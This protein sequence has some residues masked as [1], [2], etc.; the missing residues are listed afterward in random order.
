MTTQ[1]TRHLQSRILLLALVSLLL[2]GLLAAGVTAFAYYE[3][4]RE[5]AELA[6]EMNLRHHSLAIE[7]YFQRLEDIA[8]QVASRSRIRDELAAYQEDETTL[9]DL[10][11]FTSGKLADALAPSGAAGIIR[12][13]AELDRVLAVGDVEPDAALWPEL[14]QGQTTISR[15]G[16]VEWEGNGYLILAV[17]IIDR[18]DRWLGADIIVFPVEPLA[19]ILARAGDADTPAHLSSPEGVV[20]SAATGRQELRDGL[21]DEIRARL[22]SPPADEWEVQRDNGKVLFVGPVNGDWSLV[23]Q[24]PKRALYAEVGVELGM[25]VGLVLAM[26]ML[27][28]LAMLRMM[29]PLSSQVVE[30]AAALE[31]ATAEQEDLLEYAH[32]FVYRFDNHGQSAYVSPG[33]QGVLGYPPSVLP[34]AIHEALMSPF[35]PYLSGAA[36]PVSGEGGAELPPARVT[37]ERRGGEMVVLELNAR[38]QYRADSEQ[39]IFGVARDV[40]DRE[41]AERRVQHLAHY[42]TLTDLPNRALLDDRL[43][44]ALQRA[45]RRDARLALLFVDLDGFKY[46]ND[47]LGHHRG[48]ELLQAVAERLRGGLRAED[49][50]ARQGGDEFVM[51]VESIDGPREAEQVAQKVLGALGEPFRIGGDELFVGASIGISLFPDDATEA[52][53]LI[54]NADSAMFR[55]KARG[56]NNIQFYTEELTSVNQRRLILEAGLRRAIEGGELEVVYQPQWHLPGRELAGAEALVR[57]RHPEFGVISPAEF[58]PVAEENGTI[59]LLGCWVLRRALEQ[60][61]AWGPERVGRIGVNL[62]GYQ[63]LYGDIVATVDAV[64]EETGFPATRLE[65]EI[66]EGFVMDHAERGIAVLEELRDRGVQ[67]AIDDFGTGYSSFSY[68][69]RLPVHRLK[70][71]ASFVQGVDHNPADASLTAS[72]IAMAHKLGLEVVAEGVETAEQLAYIIGEQCDEAQGYYLDHPLSPEDFANRL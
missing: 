60:V 48:D 32:G 37:V 72:I 7:Q 47:S 66:T 4:A 64:L 39:V 25:P 53:T 5:R 69:K 51:V 41:R 38:I 42:D 52:E 27:G 56:R 35:L 63:I 22:P 12:L 43:K 18:D 14:E 2:T 55:A 31:R 61:M 59:G 20:L 9:A 65:L 54:R 62:S 1:E 70:V 30:Q 10:R 13:D 34:E 28:G 40:T 44:K 26:A 29:R 16:P 67:L 68:L 49:T 50:I 3:Q 19:G 15:R 11:T 45:Q 8:W 57:W 71:D 24:V 46:V 17:P 6:R 58:I 36:V 33:V 23:S 21:P